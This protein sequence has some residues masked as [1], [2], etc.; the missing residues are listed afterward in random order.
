[1][2]DICTQQRKLRIF[3]SGIDIKEGGDVAIFHFRSLARY[4]QEPPENNSI[5]CRPGPSVPLT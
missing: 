1:M 2:P 5:S 4:G 3:Q